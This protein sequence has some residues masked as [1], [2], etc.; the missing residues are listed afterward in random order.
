LSSIQQKLKLMII[1]FQNKLRETP[2]NSI[3]K[4]REQCPICSWERLNL[5]KQIVKFNVTRNLNIEL[6]I[7]IDMLTAA[8]YVSGIHT[9]PI[10]SSQS[11]N[12]NP[13]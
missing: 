3:L 13:W 11:T 1:V 5:N 2:C 4:L 12:G 7:T 9:M 10:S 6:R 8:P